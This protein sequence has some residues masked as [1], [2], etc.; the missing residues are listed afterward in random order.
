MLRSSLAGLAA[1]A[2]L[3]VGADATAQLVERD[4][5]DRPDAFAPAGVMGDRLPGA[6]TLD[7]QLRLQNRTFKRLLAGRD[8][9]PPILVLQDWAM[10]PLERSSTR[11][12]LEL[13]GGIYDWL[14]LSLRAPFVHHEVEFATLNQ[15]MTTSASGVGDVELHALASLHDTWPVRA[16]VGL[17]ASFPTGSVSEAG[18]TVDQ[19]GSSRILPY[20]MQTG[21]GVFALLP[22]AMVALENR[23]GTTGIQVT[24]RV[25]F[26]E[27]D[28]DWRPGN[29]FSGS[30]FGQSRVNDWFGL[31]ARVALDNSGQVQ[32]ADPSLSP[33]ASP[34]HTPWAYGGTRIEAPVG[35]NLRFAEGA[36]RGHR[37]G[38][39]LVVP[40]HSDLNGPQNRSSWGVNFSWGYTFGT[41]GPA[42]ARVAYAV[43]VR[44]QPAPPA[45]APA[46]E[47]PPPPAAP[48]CPAIDA[49]AAGTDWF[50][51]DLAIRFE[52]LSYVRAGGIVGP[53]CTRL[54][55]VG[56]ID[57]VPLFAYQGATRPF[58]E[59]LVPVREGAWQGYRVELAR[60][61]G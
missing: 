16:H 46:S 41:R 56:R 34:L 43:P 45:P 42:A 51:E 3:L 17:G 44:A 23:Y 9:I 37:L 29:S 58:P 54:V 57:A 40:L 60:V 53:D 38:A 7:L 61:R 28:R 50:E 18:T 13:T 49:Y 30:I 25:H 4:W 26:G 12:T 21:A 22:T 39:E 14:A 33:G 10:V 1:G 36:L 55:Q 5:T 24:S 32:G 47:S 6:R 31:S 11:V 27:N 15:L 20:G 19:P 52:E 35:I 2:V 8:E 48:A 59:L